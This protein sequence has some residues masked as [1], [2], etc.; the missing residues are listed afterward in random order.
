MKKTFEAVTLV[1]TAVFLLALYFCSMKLVSMISKEISMFEIMYHRSIWGLLLLV[2]Y[3]NLLRKGDP[4][5]TSFFDGISR[6]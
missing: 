1:A 2:L 6:E 5:K 3:Q 4:E